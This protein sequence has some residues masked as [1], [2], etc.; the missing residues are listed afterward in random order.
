[1]RQNF[2]LDLFLPYLLNQ[3]AEVTSAAFQESYR[4]R[5][6]T[7]TEWRVL[8]NLGKQG[9]LTAG[10]ICRITFTDKSK[11]SR[12]VQRLE[13]AGLLQ[14][15]KVADDRRQESLTLTDAGR[16]ACHQISKL[17][18]G[19]DSALRDALGHAEAEALAQV[20]RRLIAKGQ[21]R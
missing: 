12:A 14:R 16:I 10:Q 17:A 11:V 20:L 4:A 6:M 1:M 2:D 3:A 19:F 21:G 8:A 7:R 13:V 9:A 15:T 18:A 5:G